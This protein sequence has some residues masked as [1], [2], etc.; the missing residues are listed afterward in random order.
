M[1]KNTVYDVFWEGPYK[2][3]D[4]IDTQNKLVHDG[5]CLYQI[6]GDHPCYGRDVLLYIGKTLQ[7]AATR[8]KQH[9]KRFSSQVEEVKIF[10]ASCH[11]FNS[12]EH[13][14]SIT[15]YGTIDSNTLDQI[16]SLLI[17]A[18]QPAYNSDKIKTLTTNHAFRVFNTG[19]R[20]SLLPETST[21]FWLPEK[22][23]TQPS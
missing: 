9:H 16:E 15:K 10:I 2:L 23:M 14:D 11:E 13:R 8:I 4:I 3:D 18:H 1:S 17:Y 5:H 19:R 22:E 21:E 20:K 7:G 6:Y 12:W